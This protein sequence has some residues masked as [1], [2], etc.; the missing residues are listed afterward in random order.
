MAASVRVPKGLYIASYSEILPGTSFGPTY[1][2]PTRHRDVRVVYEGARSSLLAGEV[3]SLCVEG[4]G[5]GYARKLGVG[6][7]TF[8]VI[9]QGG[10]HGVLRKR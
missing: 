2:G 4:G 1:M 6:N 3:N 10:W 9:G 5:S 8:E 7:A